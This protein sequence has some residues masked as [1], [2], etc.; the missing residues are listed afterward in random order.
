MSKPV[1]TIEGLFFKNPYLVF[2]GDIDVEYA[3]GRYEYGYSVLNTDTG[4]VEF[5]SPS[6]PDC[7]SVAAQGAAA[8]TFFSDKH[9]PDITL[10]EFI[11][12]VTLLAVLW[13]VGIT[14]TLLSGEAASE[15]ADL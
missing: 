12:V 6:L 1:E 14:V 11:G 3:G 9:N 10:R 15:L 8:L 4:V 7:I 5:N 2:L 13:S